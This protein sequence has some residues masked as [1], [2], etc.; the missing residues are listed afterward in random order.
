M[1][2]ENKRSCCLVLA[3]SYVNCNYSKNSKKKFIFLNSGISLAIEKLSWFPKVRL[4]DG[5]QKT[6]DYFKAL[7]E[8][9]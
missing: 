1:I 4:E 7:D 2:I 5:L 3:A 8:K 6:I 9:D